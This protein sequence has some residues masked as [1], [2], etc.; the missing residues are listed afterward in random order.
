[1]PGAMYTNPETELSKNFIKL[2]GKNASAIDRTL[3]FTSSFGTKILWEIP[4]AIKEPKN[5]TETF[6]EALINR[7]EDIL[8]RGNPVILFYSGG[9]DSTSTLIAFD[10]AFK[11]NANLSKEQLTI[12]TSV[13]AMY[14]NLQAWWEIVLTYNVVNVHTAMSE[15][16]LS[17]KVHYVFSENADQLFGSDKIFL[18][19]HI[20]ELLLNGNYKLTNLSSY[21]DVLNVHK[22]KEKFLF[23]VVDL[24]DKAPFEI[25]TMRELLW[26]INFTCKWQ[27]VALRA[28][29]FTNVFKNPVKLE[30]LKYVET[31]YNSVEL[32]QL[33]MCKS[34]VRWGE[35]PAANNYKMGFRNFI[36]KTHPSWNEFVTKKV[37]LGSLYNVIKHRSYNLNVLKI[38]NGVITAE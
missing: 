29:C 26:W 5:I 1:M 13:D 30:D 24:A 23:K 31:F 12:A 21:L 20:E 3:T 27:S 35:I 6:N 7:A 2:V 38:N 33:S 15:M 32:Q 14:E 9:L 37:K 28:L 34:F 8:N 25:T 22:N 17:K 4:T 11:R 36:N 18:Y 10:E 19:P 16:D